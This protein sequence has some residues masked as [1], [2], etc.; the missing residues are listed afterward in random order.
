MSR[1]IKSDKDA[2]LKLG[3]LQTATTKGQVSLKGW[4]PSENANSIISAKNAAPTRTDLD[5]QT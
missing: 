2:Y 1:V 5:K 3:N 4:Q